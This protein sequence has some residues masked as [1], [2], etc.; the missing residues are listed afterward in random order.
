M[1]QRFTDKCVLTLNVYGRVA[2]AK[3]D[4]EP[5]Q[6]IL[7]A[8]IQR[9]Q[10]VR[11]VA[12]V[13]RHGDRH[14]HAQYSRHVAGLLVSSSTEACVVAAAYLRAG[15]P[16]PGAALRRDE[17]LLLRYSFGSFLRRLLPSTD[18]DKTMYVTY[19][20]IGEYIIIE[21]SESESR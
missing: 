4:E 20:V 18:M 1:Q 11:L 8:G 6:L 9:E 3:V 13:L 12:V 19:K 21:G 16:Y 5:V 2:H 10:H 14:G 7:E 15:A 17:N